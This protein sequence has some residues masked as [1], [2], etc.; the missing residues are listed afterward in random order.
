[1]KNT[2]QKTPMIAIKYN[3]LTICPS[4]TCSSAQSEQKGQQI[5]ATSSC[6][7][8][9]CSNGVSAALCS[10]AML[11]TAAGLERTL[12]LVVQGDNAWGRHRRRRG[13]R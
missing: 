4:A 12:D 3:V 11:Y 13:R 6:Q 8:G 7:Q 9:A 5:K 1:M 2:K 10:L